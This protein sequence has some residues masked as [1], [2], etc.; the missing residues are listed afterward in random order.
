MPDFLH[1][2]LQQWVDDQTAPALVPSGWGKGAINPGDGQAVAP[3][4][5]PSTLG[6]NRFWHQELNAFRASQEFMELAEDHAPKDPQKDPREDRDRFGRQQFLNQAPLHVYDHPALKNRLGEWAFTDGESLFVCQSALE[7][8]LLESVD[9]E[10]FE[11]NLVQLLWDALWKGG[12][13]LPDSPR[14]K[15]EE[16]RSALEDAGLASMVPMVSGSST[17]PVSQEEVSTAFLDA[18]IPLPEAVLR[19]AFEKALLAVAAEKDLS[20]IVCQLLEDCG[21]HL[22]SPTGRQTALMLV[23]KANLLFGFDEKWM[24]ELVGE[25]GPSFFAANPEKAVSSV[26]YPSGVTTGHAQILVNAMVSTMAGGM[27]LSY[28]VFMTKA[29]ISLAMMSF[30]HVFEPVNAV[31]AALYG[32]LCQGQD[33]WLEQ[34]KHHGNLRQT[35]L[36]ADAFLIA[37]A[38]RLFSGQDRR[39]VD[40]SLVSAIV[41]QL[42]SNLQDLTEEESKPPFR[43]VPVGLRCLR[44]MG[45]EFTKNQPAGGRDRTREK[46]DFFQRHGFDFQSPEALTL[47]TSAALSQVE[48]QLQSGDYFD[49]LAHVLTTLKNADATLPARFFSTMVAECNNEIPSRQG[50]LPFGERLMWCLEEGLVSEAGFA[51]GEFDLVLNVLA[52]HQN[53]SVYTMGARLI[54]SRLLEKVPEPERPSG[55]PPSRFRL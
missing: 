18:S 34:K 29:S 14:T 31:P 53:E 39:G 24:A 3:V 33:R 17:G 10:D 54:Q 35:H 44:M 49:F 32:W 40:I 38:R 28:Y 48:T 46:M 19:P 15:P 30:H 43:K 12:V 55:P 6:G 9:S 20:A 27:G 21:A 50:A 51:S 41:A 36:V 47:L 45:P 22:S 42:G 4:L 7:S 1:P 8:V 5:T 11:I 23:N 16:V 25:E 13:W 26:P 37:S 2:R 52:T